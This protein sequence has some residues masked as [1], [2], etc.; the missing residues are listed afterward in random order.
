[1]IK[2]KMLELLVL[3]MIIQKEDSLKLVSDEYDWEQI[4]ERFVWLLDEFLEPY[5][6][7]SN[8]KES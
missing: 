2:E 3:K 8:S 7:E 6:I 1:M 5:V 4:H